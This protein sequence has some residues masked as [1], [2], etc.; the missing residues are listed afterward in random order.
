MQIKG[1]NA[2]QIVNPTGN[3]IGKPLPQIMINRCISK[4]TTIG[5]NKTTPGL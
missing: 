3:E 1:E 2:W 5:Q 4:G